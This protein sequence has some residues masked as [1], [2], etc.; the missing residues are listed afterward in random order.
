VQYN[1]DEMD[2]KD[3]IS[4]YKK[5][6]KKK[7]AAQRK[8]KKLSKKCKDKRRLGFYTGMTGN[9]DLNQ[10]DTMK[11]IAF[12]FSE[13][14]EGSNKAIKKKMLKKMGREQLVELVGGS[15]K[16]VEKMQKK[17]KRMKKRC[18]GAKKSDK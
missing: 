15:A 1:L 12:S 11:N 13:G 14:E 18:K 2:K 8:M 5:V 17:F 16:S 10:V 3:L 6:A 9:E 7:A 4:L